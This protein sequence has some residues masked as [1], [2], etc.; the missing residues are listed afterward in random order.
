MVNVGFYRSG[1]SCSNTG[2]IAGVFD[3]EWGHGLD[4]N[5]ANPSISSPSGEGIADMY[6]AL[7]LND[8]CIG[9]NF[10]GSTCSGF[11][12]PCLTCTGVRDIDYANRQSGQPHTYTWSNAHCAGVVH[13][14]GTVYAEAIWDLWK[15]DL[16][17]APFN[18]SD[19]TAHEVVT[20]LTFQGGG[21]VG[22][23][24]SGGPPSG[25]CGA[26]S[27]YMQFL[28]ADDDNGNL[29]DGT[30]HMSAI[31]DAFDRLEIA[32]LTPTP[33]NSGCA[34]IPTTA[35]TVTV[36]AFDRGASLSWNSI[37]G[38]TKYQVFRADGVFGCSFGKVKV[39][40]TTGT[41]FSDTG[42]Q[43]GREYSYIVIPI[44]GS[45]TC[46]G[47][48][49]SCASVTPV[50]GP[51]LDVVPASALLSIST[52]DGDAS[53]DNCETASLTFDVVN[54][55]IG[56]LTSARITSVTSPSHSSISV[57]T[58]F[59]SAVSPSSLPE[60]ASGSGSFGF[61]AE[62]LNF[63]DTVTFL[64]QVTAD[65]LSG[66]VK[67]QT[68]DIF[69]AESDDLQNVPSWTFSFE[70]DAEGW[71][72]VEGTFNRASSGGGAQGTWYEASSAY[73]NDQCDHI[74]SPLMALSPTSTLS[75]W[76]QFEIEPIY[77]SETWYDRAN[78]GIF[79]VDSGSRTPV[80]P[81]GGRT[82]NASG[83][84]GTCGT[85]GQ[86]G[87]AD[88]AASW[89]ESTWSAA[90]LG[91]AAVAGQL[92]QL[93]VRYGTD[94]SV[95]G[96]GFRFDQVTVTDV[97]VQV[98]D[99]QPDNCNS[100]C[101]NDA[102]CDDSLFCN[103]AEFCDFGTCTANSPVDC[104]DFVA[105]TADSCN[106]ITDSCD[107]IATDAVCDNELF[108]DGL[109]FCNP[110]VGCQ[111]GVAVDCD[112]SITCTID[113]CN[114]GTDACDHLADDSLCDDG[115]FCDGVETC[116]PSLDCQVGS[117]PCPGQSC[118]EV[119]NTCIGGGPQAQLEAGSVSVGGTAVTVNLTNTYVSPVVVATLQYANN[120]TPTVTRISVTST[121]FDV[122]LQ[123]PSGGPVATEN[124]S[125]LVVEEGTWTIDGHLV[126]AQTYT[127]TVT[128]EKNSWV[129]EM[130]SYKQSYTNPVVL[131][132]VMSV[133]DPDFSVFWDQGSVRTDPPS[134][135]AL[136]TG[137]TVAEDSDVTRSDETVGF[138]VIEA[139]HGTIGGVEFEAALGTDTVKGIEKKP[140]YTYTFN[141]P[142]ASAPSIALLTMA[143]V[144]SNEGAW[145]QVYGATLATATSL[146]LSV[147]E[148]QIG[149]TD[150][151]HTH[152]QVGYLVFA[153]PLVFSPV[154]QCELDADCDDGLSCNGAEFCDSGSCQAGTPVDC[155]DGVA[156]TVDSCNEE[157]DSCDNGT[158]DASCDNG[159]FCDGTE[160][161][162]ALADCQAGTLV[163]CDDGVGCTVDSCNEE[164]DSC[165][166]DANDASC[167]NGFFCDGTETCDALA[168]CQAG[169]LVNCDDGV[170]CTV[171]S[172]NEETDSC[173]NDAS[174]ALCDNALFCDGDETCDA[175]LD[176]Q[177]GGDPCPGQSCDE[178][179][180]TCGA[181]APVQVSFT[182]I[183]PQDGWVRESSENSSLGDKSNTGGIQAGDDKKDRQYRSILSFDTSSIPNGAAILSATL[184]LRRSGLKGGNP[185]PG[186]GQC[187]VDIRTGGFGGSTGLVSGDFEAAP[188]AAVVTTLSNAPSNGDLSEGG[189]NAAGLVAINK[190]GVTQFR[191]YFEFGDNDDS[192]DDYIKYSGGEDAIPGNRPTLL[193]VYQE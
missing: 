46:M 188:S 26:S 97:T 128:D 14:V 100:T 106:E 161:C 157:T 8:S 112:D 96:F 61:T 156:C 47:P 116:D 115:D 153:G 35:P 166:N 31:F 21:N 136:T 158:N 29:N 23:W 108:C 169:T 20:R 39:G 186:L 38:A 80:N 176:C 179:T 87:W 159:F 117:D 163:N 109:E 93:D 15:R 76:S 141:T 54:S 189:L 77:Q 17:A 58:T 191:V 147:D 50:V 91:S 62:G 36:S 79:E 53:I 71:Q 181:G 27:G 48:A 111:D 107:N 94:Q 16:T 5:D 143:G 126:E 119:G 177:P 137:K 167:D 22:S 190:T 148:D 41:S 132:Q 63:G 184:Q 88:T 59:P 138:I 69:S 133:N 127:S 4:D 24:F 164:T 12:D 146:F 104:N 74:R 149:D 139:G 37:A 118:D 75:F 144:D 60:G 173:D 55:G 30:P 151:K 9:R 140:P 160:T 129:G 110:D 32:C 3:H 162:D 44:G 86:D 28:A 120:T 13:C 123:N 171:D 34:G 145:A 135:A 89:G 42:L 174:D 175:E 1:G 43:N 2:E 95:V 122:R 49:F 178:D 66:T 81:D 56:A 182:S 170:G 102:E 51:N 124:V 185:F 78:V 130:Q 65:E 25:G 183:G 113:S 84:Q 85:A 73:L 70:S 99:V 172:C 192:S 45:D 64:V 40:E 33:Q 83:F 101:S 150:R 68:L 18:M 131:G 114:G 11:G 19:D 121:S 7:R 92:I 82:Y 10:R 52:G 168:D 67:S 105:C 90:A 57:T 103:G 98:P 125:Y 193:I 72:V 142:F 165:D 6:M 180:N 152:E 134:A 155:D 187:R 154:A